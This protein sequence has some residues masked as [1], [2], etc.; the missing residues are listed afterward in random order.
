MNRM[1]LFLNIEPGESQLVGWMFLHSF[2]LGAA[3]NFLQTAAFAIF[4][5]R[6]NSQTLAWV[7]IANAVIVPLLMALYLRL[8]GRVPFSQL[9]KI[10]L[11]F[12]LVLMLVF[13]I[14]LQ[15]STANLLIFSLPILFQTLV[16][17]GNLEFWSLAARLFDVRQGKRLF[18]LIGAGL[19]LAIVLTGLLIPLMVGWLGTANLLIFSVI[20]LAGA[21]ALLLRITR[22]NAARLTDEPRHSTADSSSPGRKKE[23]L[24]AIFRSRYLRLI[25]SLVTVWWLA[26]FFLDNIF[27]DRAAAQYPGEQQLASFLGLFLAVVGLIT[28][29]NNTFLTGRVISG[30]GIR[31]SLLILPLVMVIG[32]GGMSIAG[33]AAAALALFWL[34]MGTKLLDLAIGFSIDRSA[35]TILYQPLPVNQ[36]NRIQ[37]TAEGI[38][39]PFANGLAGLGLLALGALFG[40]SRLPLIYTLFGISLVWLIVSISIGSEYPRVLTQALTR[41]RLGTSDLEAFDRSCMNVLERGLHSESPEEVIYSLNMLEACAPENFQ[42]ALVDLVD[43]PIPEVRL[44]ALQWI[45]RLAL[46][47]AMPQVEQRLEAETSPTLRAA[48]VRALARLDEG[49][50]CFDLVSQSL[51]DHEPIVQ[52][53]AMVGLMRSGG[54]A[55]VIAA[56]Q[57]L[58]ALADSPEPS[59]RVIA[60]QTLEEVGATSYFQPLIPLLQDSDAAVQRAALRAAGAIRNPRLWPLVLD[61]LESHSVRNAAAIALSKAGQEVV[62]NLMEVFERQGQD[63]ETQAQILSVFGRIGG[64]ANS[65][66]LFKQAGHSEGLVRTSALRALDQIRYRA[67][68]EDLSDMYERIHFEVVRAAEVLGILRD[69]D[70]AGNEQDTGLLRSALLETLEHGRERVFLMLALVYDRRAILGARDNLRL[71][72]PDKRAYALEAL[73]VLIAPEIKREVFSF[74]T[75][76]DTG[77]QGMERLSTQLL[78]EFPQDIAS[79][80]QRLV[81]LIASPPGRFSPWT[82]A[83]ALYT[84]GALK[85]QALVPIVVRALS[86]SDPLVRETA[87]WALHQLRGKLARQNT[88]TLTSDPDPRVARAAKQLQKDQLEATLLTTIEKVLALKKASIFG[89][90]PDEVLLQVAPLL[91]ERLVQPGDPV[92]EKGDL[93]DCMYIV[94]DGEMR[95]HDGERTLNILGPG[96]CFGEIAV[97][98]TEPRTAS[99]T[100]YTEAQLL[101]LAQESLYEAMDVHPMVARGIIR[102]LTRNLRERVQDVR[103]LKAKLEA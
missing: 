60:A 26:F 44:A 75:E 83:S 103:E 14:G 11:G 8:G 52:R 38:F 1:A 79:R 47:A 90:T 9:L 5:V 54:I 10:N 102:A 55:G 19:W 71:P 97:L 62:P 20:S 36:R 88:S 23:G 76:L 12:L 35:L 99:V 65:A 64:E 37:V 73:D 74:L 28:L 45:D 25:F 50:D 77:T 16:N 100:A 82:L 24:G 95:V 58:L 6:F 91:E 31:S 51:E 43:H 94:V 78:D 3:N 30:F 98:D 33:L 42:K 7:Y 69:L 101:R 63:R 17:F 46:R 66:W 86:A 15:L 67:S 85:S 87:V 80:D 2:L 27:Y 61:Q 41:R 40:G 49:G 59:Q 13:W 57:K 4:L 70:A 32:S 53:A 56:G 21:F 39:Q 68:T 84:T 72:F 29:I 93:G 89:E 81:E 18:G 34:T 48:S 96:A 92:I 22:R